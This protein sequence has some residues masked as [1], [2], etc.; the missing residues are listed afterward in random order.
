V[1]NELNSY[2]IHVTVKADLIP[3]FSLDLCSFHGISYLP[4]F[5]KD[6]IKVVPHDTSEPV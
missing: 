1:N 5:I 3:H 2:Y 6:R 4:L